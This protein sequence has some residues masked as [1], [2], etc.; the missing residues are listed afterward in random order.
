MFGNSF[1]NIGTI[2]KY[3]QYLNHSYISIRLPDIE[4]LYIRVPLSS[5]LLLLSQ[6][7]QASDMNGSETPVQNNLLQDDR[8]SDIARARVEPLLLLDRHGKLVLRD[9]SRY[10]SRIAEQSRV[11]ALLAKLVDL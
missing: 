10:R 5:F 9:S 7:L 8:C 6:R 2:T 4:L 3:L 11:P 1:I